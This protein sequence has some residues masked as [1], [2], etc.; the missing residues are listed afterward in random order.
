MEST[1]RALIGRFSMNKCTSEIRKFLVINWLGLVEAQ[2]F[3]GGG[4]I[5]SVLTLVDC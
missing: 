4:E 2:H 5:K 3:T 1:T